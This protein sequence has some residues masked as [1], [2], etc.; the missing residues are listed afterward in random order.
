M[1]N[2][3]TLKKGSPS[4]VLGRF[5]DGQVIHRLYKGGLL[6]RSHPNIGKIDLIKAIER[7]SNIYFSLL[8]G[9]VIRDPE[10]LI[11]ACKRFRCGKKRGIDLPGE[12][13]GFLPNDLSYNR[14]GLY[15]FAIG[16]HSLAVTPLQSAVMMGAIANKGRLLKPRVVQAFAGREPLR[17]Y[18]SPFFQQ[19]AYPFQRDLGLAGIHFLPLFSSMQAEIEKPSVWYT[20]PEIKQTLPLARLDALHLT[21]RDARRG[22]R[23]KWNGASGSHPRAV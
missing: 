19:S 5:L 3:D 9:D 8:V 13:A 14:T 15:S 2:K 12:I 23:P 1:I 17:E 20:P 11:D 22:L 18:R 21:R 7:S 10:D 6:P 16:Q 4:Q